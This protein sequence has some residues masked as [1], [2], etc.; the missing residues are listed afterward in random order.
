[1][2]C[3]EFASQI[4]NKLFCPLIFNRP[5]LPIDEQTMYSGFKWQQASQNDLTVVC[6][7]STPYITTALLKV[8]GCFSLQ[9]D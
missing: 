3:Q 6:L 7:L 8:V 2:L 4:A 1:M 5:L 9:G